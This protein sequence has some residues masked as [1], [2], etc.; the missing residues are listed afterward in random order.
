MR[1]IALLAAF[2]RQLRIWHIG[3]HHEYTPDE[4]SRATVV[5]W[6]MAGVKDP[7]QSQLACPVGSVFLFADFLIC[8][9]EPFRKGSGQ[10]AK[11]VSAKNRHYK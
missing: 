2:A 1:R 4:A 5:D 10:Q 6:L 11:I 7:E 3:T 8:P 9:T